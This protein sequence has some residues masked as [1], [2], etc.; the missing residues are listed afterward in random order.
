MF[1]V[2]MLGS[3]GAV[4]SPDR[5]VS[6][7][8]V[9]C[10]G[11]VYLLDACEG[12]QRQMM[13]YKL[14]YFKTTAIFISHLHPD[15]YLGIPGLVFTLQLS[16]F[17]DQLQIIGPP[18]TK[19]MVGNLLNDSVPDFVKVYEFSGDMQVYECDEFI[20]KAF[21]VEHIDESYGFVIEQ[22]P[23]RKFDENKAKALGISGRMF[24][25]IEE[26][27]GVNINGRTVLLDEISWVESGVK[28]AYSGDTVYYEGMA[29]HIE[30][31]DLLIHDA[32]F[33]EK[34]RKDA[35]E[36]RHATAEDAA[37]IAKLAKCRKL[38]L[39]HISNRYEDVGGHLE[40]A[41]RIFEDAVVAE[42]GLE[43]NV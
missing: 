8:G 23:K 24:R 35:D 36:K 22:R 16:D 17:K 32:T 42:D 14:S 25:E 38:V 3:G 28:V 15:H 40:E 18:G 37:R 5:S 27:G 9:R 4:P 10:N 2:V 31:A 7:V 11:K 13:R 33:T 41:K 21:R 29:G 12:V 34:N 30:N 20:V 19:R 43:L 39:T 6:C 1:R 26:K